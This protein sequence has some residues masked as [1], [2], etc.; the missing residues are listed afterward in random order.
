[1]GNYQ[2]ANALAAQTTIKAKTLCL[3]SGIVIRPIARPADPTP[4]KDFT[5]IVL[6]TDC[7]SFLWTLR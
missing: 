4:L 5:S 6:P 7:W 2:P 1:M 3:I